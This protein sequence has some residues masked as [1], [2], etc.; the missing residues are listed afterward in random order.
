MQK[1]LEELVSEIGREIFVRVDLWTIRMKIKDVKISYGRWL[2]L[3]V[4]VAGKG[5]GWI[6]SDRII[7]R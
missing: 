3:V 1:S 5:E 4:P 6:T 7:T 2:F